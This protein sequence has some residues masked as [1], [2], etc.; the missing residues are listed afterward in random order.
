MSPSGLLLAFMAVSIT[1]GTAAGVMQ[2][3]VPLYAISLSVSQAGV[4]VIRGLAQ[5]GGLLTSLPGGFLIDRY[6]ARR[7]YT[8]AC[9][10]D[11]LI[12]VL[13]PT[14]TKV[15]W[16]TA[17][18]FLE[19]ALGTLR[20]TTINS[21]FF[22]RLETFGHAR[23]GWT[24]ASLA[25]GANFIGPLAGGVLSS[26]FSY[27]ASYLVV[28]LIV[29]A[30]VCAIPLF[31]GRSVQTVARGHGDSGSITDQFRDLITNRPLWRVALL[32]STGISSNSAYLIYIVLLAVGSNGLSAVTASRLLAAQGI[33]FV[34]SMFWGGRLVGRFSLR[35]L[36]SLAFGLQII[37]LLVTGCC[38]AFLLLI[39]G[40]VAFGLGSGLLTTISFS[41][42]GSMAGQKGR[43]SGLF[44]LI[45]GTGVAL[46]PLW[47]SLLVTLWGIRAAFI[48]FVPVILIAL[49]C[50][51]LPRR[52]ERDSEV[53]IQLHHAV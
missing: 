48:G 6:G 13:I 46:G 39:A 30:P 45:T 14:F 23:A 16:L 15:P 51:L 52:A 10:L 1:G 29:A 9:L 31:R 5:F 3:L 18:L 11:G 42:L 44:F 27:H 25:V 28:G 53:I 37:G 32:Q 40:G 41:R 50:V 8:V 49:V 35:T 17:F 19:G 12:I 33:A 36:Y 2:L 47:G 7:V 4:G 24:R 20:W 22:S 21:A 43:L 26:S 34:V 38:S